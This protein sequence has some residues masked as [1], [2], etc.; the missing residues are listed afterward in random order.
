MSGVPL[1]AGS[2]RQLDFS[3]FGAIGL[4]R[5]GRVPPPSSLSPS[6]TTSRYSS[7]PAQQGLQRHTDPRRR[8]P[9]ARQPRD[10]RT[11]VQESRGCMKHGPSPNLNSERDMLCVRRS[12]VRPRCRRSFRGS[13]DRR[14]APSVAADV[15]RH[16]ATRAGAERARRIP[17]GPPAVA[18][19][20]SGAAGR[21]PA[22]GQE[23]RSTALRALNRSRSLCVLCS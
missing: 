5:F 12:G 1:P 10:R 8:P 6:S 17:F 13:C 2:N 7:L 21:D 19:K 14:V 4:Q 15:G 16:H 3:G 23:L 18:A 22:P 20:R 11:R 9:P